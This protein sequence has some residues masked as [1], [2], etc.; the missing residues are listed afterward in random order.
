VLAVLVF[1]LAIA[2]SVYIGMGLVSARERRS[3]NSIATF[4]RHLA[5][6]ARTSPARPLNQAS[7]QHTWPVA[8]VPPASYRPVRRGMT[9][10]EARN[11]RRQVLTALAASASVS[12]A[13]AF[14]GNPVLLALHL[15]VDALLAGYVYLLIRTQ[16][17]AVERRT[18]VVYLRR[19][20]LPVLPVVPE[21]AYLQRSAN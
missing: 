6:L 17:A 12:A 8:G 14:L 16:Q 9:L 2:W 18:K 20:V 13:L 15:L 1:I 21:P 11:R 19:P 10:A 7:V 5:V 3:M 4:N